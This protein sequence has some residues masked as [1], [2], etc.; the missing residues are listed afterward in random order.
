[1]EAECGA[2]EFG[3]GFGEQANVANNIAW[4][5]ACFYCQHKGTQRSRKWERDFCREDRKERQGK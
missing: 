5:L 3:V 4:G 1:M 2:V